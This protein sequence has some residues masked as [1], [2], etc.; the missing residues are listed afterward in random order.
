MCVTVP[1]GAKIYQ[2]ES[3]RGVQRIFAKPE[4][5]HCEAKRTQHYN[6]MRASSLV[7]I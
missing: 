4:P 1:N 2:I 5:N 6:G 3:E 7:V